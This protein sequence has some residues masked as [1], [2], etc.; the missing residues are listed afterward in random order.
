MRV[1][2]PQQLATQL[3]F[4]MG[5]S[6]LIIRWRKISAIL[7]VIVRVAS[8]EKSCKRMTPPM[9]LEIFLFV[10]VA[11]QVAR[12]IASCNMAFRLAG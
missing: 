9:Q 2:S 8:C 12:K 1:T 10:I 6:E 3:F 5:Q 7:F 11:L 4:R